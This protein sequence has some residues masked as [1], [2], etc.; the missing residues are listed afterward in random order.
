MEIREG[1]MQLQLDLVSLEIQWMEIHQEFFWNSGIFSASIF[2]KDNFAD[3]KH[4]RM[5]T[6]IGIKKMKYAIRSAVV[7]PLVLD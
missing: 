1:Q 6:S 3:L 4:G 7:I 2:L 5:A